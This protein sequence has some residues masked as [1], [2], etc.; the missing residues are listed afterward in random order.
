MRR[1]TKL[2]Q[3]AVILFAAF[4][5]LSACKKVEKTT[6]ATPVEVLISQ[7][8]PVNVQFKSTGSIVSLT[9]PK[10]KAEIQGKITAVYVQEGQPITVGQVLAKID[11]SQAQLDYKQAIAQ[12]QADQALLNEAK[13]EETS[14]AQLVSKGII[15]KV[16]FASVVAARKT[17]EAKLTMSQEALNHAKFQLDKQ[18]VTSPVMGAVQTVSISVGDFVTA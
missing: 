12:T 11:S 6:N 8:E 14:N 5:L 2:M 16:K 3:S 13:L 9:N 18:N 4:A 1:S 10:I 17:A 15:S 7:P